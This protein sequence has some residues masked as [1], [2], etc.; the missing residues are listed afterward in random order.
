M[1][2]AFFIEI[3]LLATDIQTLIILDTLLINN[4]KKFKKQLS[5]LIK[6]RDIVLMLE[7]QKSSQ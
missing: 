1:L 6:C 2:I 5:R 7:A 4:Y 3:A